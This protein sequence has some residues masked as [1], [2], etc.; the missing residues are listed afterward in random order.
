MN[1]LLPY[2]KA[3]SDDVNQLL[4]QTAPM[5][6]PLIELIRYSL[7]EQQEALE[8][9]I[10]VLAADSEQ[11]HHEDH[12]N[13][14]PSSQSEQHSD[15]AAV[16]LDQIRSYLSILY[17]NNEVAEPTMRAWVRAVHWMPSFETEHTDQVRSRYEHMREQLD[18]IA[19]HLREMYGQ[20]AI[21][22]V[23]PTFYL[24]VS[25]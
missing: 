13:H 16:S 6:H 15:S 19:V 25:L 8:K 18:E 23:V 5:K 21:K 14:K 11:I 9:L 7:H 22:Y 2:C 10:P 20:A 4:E 17:Q 3:M 1:P 12:K 24:E